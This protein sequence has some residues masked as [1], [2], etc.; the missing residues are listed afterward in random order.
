[1]RSQSPSF[2]AGEC[3]TGGHFRQGAPLRELSTCGTV[4]GMDELTKLRWGTGPRAYAICTPESAFCSREGIVNPNGPMP[5][6]AQLHQA[7]LF[8][9]PEHARIVIA[10]IHANGFPTTEFRVIEVIADVPEA[11]WKP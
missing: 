4:K 6:F 11:R 1:M 8:L 2:I 7:A 9:S 3:P 10:A 5:L